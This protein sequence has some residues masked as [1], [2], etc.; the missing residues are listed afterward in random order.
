VSGKNDLTLTILPAAL[1]GAGLVGAV[2]VANRADHFA[3]KLQPRRHR[4][5]AGIGTIARAVEGTDALVF[6]RGDWRTIFGALAYLFFDVLVLWTAFFA[7]HAHA[8]PA[9]APVLMAYIIGALAGSLPLPAGL[10][11]IGGIGACLILY[12]A[13]R[14]A[15][16]A[17]AVFYGAVG[18]VVPLVGGVVA[19]LLLTREVR[20]LHRDTGQATQR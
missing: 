13:G 6:G 9:F 19:Y 5:A 3:A 18:L 10:G 12:G 2:V 16:V 14:N 15:A 7:L 17:A 11:A 4:I 20:S 8:V 1:A